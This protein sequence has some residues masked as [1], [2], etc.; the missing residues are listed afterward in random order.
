M[1]A[2]TIDIVIQC[3]CIDSKTNFIYQISYE[4][5]ALYT[6]ILIDAKSRWNIKT[7]F[8]L[9]GHAIQI[10]KTNK[11]TETLMHCTASCASEWVN[12]YWPYSRWMQVHFIPQRLT[13]WFSWTYWSFTF[14]GN[15]RTE[16]L[17]IIT[18]LYNCMYN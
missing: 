11:K 15:R 13:V 14:Y 1:K 16:L 10:L 6:H 2:T 17:R 18:E 8:F 3:T 12:V 9:A 5:L 7:L 4:I